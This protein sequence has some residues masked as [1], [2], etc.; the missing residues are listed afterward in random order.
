MSARMFFHRYP[1]L[2]AYLLNEVT[3]VA[4]TIRSTPTA[5]TPEES[6][7]YPV[8]IILAKLHPAT[9]QEDHEKDKYQVSHATLKISLLSEN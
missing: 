1:D 2:Y 8:L 7:L 9:S 5:V 4:E 6:A 3:N